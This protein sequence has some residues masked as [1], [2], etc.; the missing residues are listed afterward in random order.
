MTASPLLSARLRVAVLACHG[1]LLL[2]LP[3]A[4]GWLGAL[5]ALPLL[6][7]LRGLWLGRPYTHAWSSMLLVLYIGAFLMEAS[8]QPERRTPALGL[9]V[10]AAAEFCALVLF[11]RARAVERRREDVSSRAER[12]IS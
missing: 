7:P 3:A 5:L 4:G 2:A 9:A 12:G 8:A 11:V 1:L 10:I 6:G